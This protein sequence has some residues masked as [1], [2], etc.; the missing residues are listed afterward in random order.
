MY[1]RCQILHFSDTGL[2][3]QL[4]SSLH[5]LVTFNPADL[6][7]RLDRRRIR[8]VMNHTDLEGS[9]ECVLKPGLSFDIQGQCLSF[10]FQLHVEEESQYYFYYTEYLLP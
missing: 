9:C 7:V 1:Q 8:L 2:T 4:T 5:S 10:A 3:T 6:Q